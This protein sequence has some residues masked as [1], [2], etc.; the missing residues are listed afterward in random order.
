MRR[1]SNLGDEEGV[2]QR[3]SYF[4]RAFGTALAFWVRSEANTE[5]GPA[6]FPVSLRAA[7]TNR[8]SKEAERT[9]K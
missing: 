6:W 4:S 8:N 5:K 9:V 7:K 2:A 3:A 1:L